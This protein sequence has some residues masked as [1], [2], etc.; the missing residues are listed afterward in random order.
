MND[1]TLKE[2]LARM[3]GKRILVLGD[4]MLD[5]YLWG[6]VRRISPE[7]PVPVVEM[8]SRTYVPGG[9]GNTAANV[10][11]LG[12]EALLGGVTG[13]DSQARLL[14]DAL[15]ERGVSAAG[16]I[17]DPG[18]QTTTKTRII[19]HSQQMVRVDCEQK[20]ALPP[21]VEDELLG[22]VERHMSRVDACIL[23]DYSKGVVSTRLAEHVIRLARAAGKAVVV[24]PKGT[25]YAKY[26]G[27]TIVKPNIHEAERFLKREISSE[28]SLVKG[29]RR[30]L[31]NLRDSALLVTRGAQGMSL[32]RSGL[33]PLHIPSVARAVFD[34]TG[35]GDTVIGTLALSVAA[36]APL[37]QA[38][39][40]ANRAAGIVVGKVGTTTISLQDLKREI[41]SVEAGQLPSRTGAAVGGRRNGTVA[42]V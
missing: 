14:S 9:A 37:D 32:F 13:S 38:V 8:R 29:G 39:R 6:E 34:V 18:R 33:R 42:C 7:A 30:L 3:P 25:D 4:V 36:G 21:Q 31:S 20:T 40:L 17:R 22:W 15:E 5:E 12:G 35:A 23:S 2:T 28:A 24:D 16:L 26:R 1:L 11:S 27:A 10:A 19:A 41:S